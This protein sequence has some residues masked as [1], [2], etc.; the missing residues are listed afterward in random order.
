VPTAPAS[1][2]ATPLHFEVIFWRSSTDVS[3][4]EMPPCGVLSV[5][6]GPMA[7]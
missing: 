1:M 6:R 5:R 7:W 4:S 3:T 2:K